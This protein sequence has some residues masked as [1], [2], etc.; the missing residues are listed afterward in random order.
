MQKIISLFYLFVSL[1]FLFLPKLPSDY[2]K[3]SLGAIENIVLKTLFPM[4]VLSKVITLN[5]LENLIKKS[6]L[7][8]NLSLSDSLIKTVIFGIVAGFPSSSIEIEK[9]K[10]KGVINEREAKK[11]LALSSAPSF[12]F[13]V[14][15]AGK[16]AFHGLLLF[17]LSLSVSY[18][19]AVSEKSTKSNISYSQKAYSLPSAISSSALS[20]LVVSANIIFFNF[21]LSLF[22][23]LPFSIVLASFL[24]LS[25]GAVLLRGH[26]LLFS[27]LVGFGSL[28]A[29]F[30]IKSSA[31]S[32]SVSLYLKA[33][34]LTALIF[35]MLEISPIL[36]LFLSFILILIKKTLKKKQLGFI[37]IEK[38]L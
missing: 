12:A 1:L 6:K 7:W 19:V 34:L 36:T 35:V 20:V 22:S 33:R 37:I 11:A 5:F 9:L 4:M 28:S 2:V 27:F 17:F 26:S 14:K 10:T 8:K 18:L 13:M 24:E 38:E 32:V 21:L 16:N 3:I 31:E 23:F 15:V 25:S 29:L 30:Q